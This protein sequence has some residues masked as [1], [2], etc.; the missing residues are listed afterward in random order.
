MDPIVAQIIIHRLQTWQLSTNP[1]DFPELQEKYTTVLQNQDAQGW[2]NFWMGLPSKGWL[3][4]Q[5]AHY[6]RIASSKTESSWLIALIRKQWLTAWEI[7]DYQNGV[8][9]HADEGTD[10]QRVA[11]EIRAEYTLGPAS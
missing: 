1:D 8:V 2:Q 9:H 11:T 3:E 10:A 4:L 6:T 7:W 5:E